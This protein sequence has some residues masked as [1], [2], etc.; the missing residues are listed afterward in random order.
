MY[1]QNN[2]TLSLFSPTKINTR[3][4]IIG[5]YVT[6]T[7]LWAE[8]GSYVPLH[9]KT[10]KVMSPAEILIQRAAEYQKLVEDIEEEAKMKTETSSGT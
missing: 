7:P 3:F 6:S 9:M 2:K 8:D 4:R 1:L 10:D 5:A